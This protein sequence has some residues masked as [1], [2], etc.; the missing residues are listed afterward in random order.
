MTT[1]GNN[2]QQLKVKR[3]RGE[4]YSSLQPFGPQTSVHNTNDSQHSY[5]RSYF[6]EQTCLEIPGPFSNDSPKPS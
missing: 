5:A 1:V 4:K 2:H 6:H 3:G